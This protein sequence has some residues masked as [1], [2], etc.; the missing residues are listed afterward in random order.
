MEQ[1]YDLRDL[2]TVIR[3][4]FIWLLIIPTLA[5]M[6][7]GVI[8]L[9]VISPIYEASTT[10]LIG[11]AQDE[12]QLGYQDVMLNRQLIS[13][14]SELARSRSVTESVINALR[15]DM[16]IS[17]LAGQISVSSVRDTE[18]LAVRVENEDPL[19]ATRIANQVAKSFSERVVGYS[20]I[21]NVTVVDEAIKPEK[22]VSPNL[23]RNLAIT[24]FIAIFFAVSLIFFIEFIDNTIKTTADVEYILGLT[25]LAEVPVHGEGKGGR[26]YG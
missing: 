19:L 20:N 22:P 4:R 26:K 17:E 21:N 1:G 11:R 16:S 24:G 18:I 9:Y 5:I 7:C 3:K 13:T 23:K 14:Y 12:T 15:L 6:I 8:T 10:L 2:L 25:V